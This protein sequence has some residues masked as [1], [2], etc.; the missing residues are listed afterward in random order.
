MRTVAVTIK[1]GTPVMARP[2]GYEDH[3]SAR[4]IRL[5]D[6]GAWVVCDETPMLRAEDRGQ[7]VWAPFSGISVELGD[8]EISGQ[9]D[10]GDRP[11][12]DEVETVLAGEG[13]V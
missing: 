7:A 12:A 9:P 1:A 8:C 5:R 10:R 11:T 2:E 3:F 13:G 4:I 6:G